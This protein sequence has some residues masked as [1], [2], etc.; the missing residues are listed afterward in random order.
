MIGKI[1]LFGARRLGAA[2]LRNIQP[3]KT[4]YREVGQSGAWPPHSK[5]ISLAEGYSHSIVL[6]GFE[7]MS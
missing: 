6:G 2:S 5:E 1:E 3:F 7:L 4:R